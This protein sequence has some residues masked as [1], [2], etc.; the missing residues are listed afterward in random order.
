MAELKKD[1]KSTLDE[2]SVMFG[3]SKPIIYYIIHD[4]LKLKKLGSV[5]VHTLSLMTKKDKECKLSNFQL[6]W[7]KVPP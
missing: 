3:V 6:G 5:Y 1:R 7:N 4:C 2:L